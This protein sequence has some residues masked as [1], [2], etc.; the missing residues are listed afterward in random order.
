MVHLI[1]VILLIM[2]KGVLGLFIWG[3]MNLIRLLE[4]KKLRL[5]CRMGIIG[6]YMIILGGK[7]NDESCVV[8]FNDKNWKVSKGSLVVEKDVK[9]GTLYLCIGYIVPLL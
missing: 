4:R 2:S 3:I 7:L 9:V 5:S 8:T 6:Y 1:E